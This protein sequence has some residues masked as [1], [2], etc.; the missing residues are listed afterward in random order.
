MNDATYIIRHELQ[1]IELKLKFLLEEIDKSMILINTVLEKIE[2]LQDEYASFSDNP[3]PTQ[4][5]IE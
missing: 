4:M 1:K 3:Y 5:Y 2:T